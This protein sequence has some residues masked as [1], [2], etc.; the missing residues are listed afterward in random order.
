MMGLIELEFRLPICPLMEA[1]RKL[2]KDCLQEYKL[3]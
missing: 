3:V 2:L 1:N